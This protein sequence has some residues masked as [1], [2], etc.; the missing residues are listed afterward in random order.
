MSCRSLM[1]WLAHY[2]PGHRFAQRLLPWY[3]NGS[4]DAQH[5]RQIASHAH[6]CPSCGEDL[7]LLEA[8]RTELQDPA[9]P[10]HLEANLTRMMAAID[11]FEVANETR[12]PRRASVPPKTTWLA[13]LAPIVPSQPT[14]PALAWALIL[15]VV[16]VNTAT[17]IE[18]SPE[19][20]AISSFHVLGAKQVESGSEARE[21][22]V[23]FA[24][25]LTNSEINRIL[26]PV[27]AELVTGPSDLGVYTVRIGANPEGGEAVDAGAV[28][29]RLRGEPGVILAEP[30]V[31]TP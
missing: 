24:P 16:A 28:A 2:S 21:L 29:R 6:E 23:V 18:R 30:I 7:Q 15:G 1:R 11:R 26:T 3:A 10:D 27:R 5:T 20:T 17:W 9:F 31:P 8:Y 25:A 12:A 4:L 19:Q 22:Q 13:K 14:S